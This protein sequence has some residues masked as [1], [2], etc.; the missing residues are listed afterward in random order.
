MKRPIL[1]RHERLVSFAASRSRLDCGVSGGPVRAVAGAWEWAASD[2]SATL[3]RSQPRNRA[4][5]SLNVCFS[6]HLVKTDNG[7]HVP[8]YDTVN[9]S[10]RS[11]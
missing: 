5:H 9:P 7:T 2:M 8:D 11:W 1:V 4:K 10:N 3:A 6:M